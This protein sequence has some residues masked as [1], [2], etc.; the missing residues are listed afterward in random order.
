VNT[1]FRFLDEGRHAFLLVLEGEEAVEQAAFE[2]DALGQWSR[3][4]R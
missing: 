3:G 1:G 4:R 2:L